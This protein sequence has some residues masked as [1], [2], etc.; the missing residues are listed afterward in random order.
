[1]QIWHVIDSLEVG[2]AETVV[3]TLCREQQAAGH[4]PSVHCLLRAGKIAKDLMEDGIPV[5]VYGPAPLMDIARRMFGL[6]RS[7]R[8]DVLHC[9]NE[10]P[11]I[12]CAPAARLAGV[13]SVIT[14]YHG[15]VVPLNA[16]R[17]KFWMATRFCNK[18]VAV[19]RTT[20]ANLERSPISCPGR[21]VTLYN[22]AAPAGSTGFFPVC[23]PDEFPIVNVARH[24]PAKDILTLLRA[25]AIARQ[26]APDLVLLLAGSGV[27]TDSL[28]QSTTELGLDAS[29]RFLGEQSDVGGILRQSKLFV[30][31]SINEGLPIS[32]LEAMSAGLPQVVTAVGGM[33]EI[34]ELSQSGIAAPPQDPPALAAAILRFRDD[35][36]WRLECGRRARECYESRFTPARMAADYFSLY[37]ADRR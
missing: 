15:M 14:T 25:F 22:S 10:T 8:P 24:V 4:A 29:V 20:Q 13:R 31:S 26:K 11:T 9:H 28:K 27:L 6:M 33:A 18:V 3:A 17:L 34:M 35:E 16:P 1:M 37:T 21:I 19:S 30:L 32:L 12:F 5:H 2:G 36:Q 23:G 7:Q